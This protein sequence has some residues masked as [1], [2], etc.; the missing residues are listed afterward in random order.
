MA[1]LA[2]LAHSPHIRPM[3][4]LQ[5]L[6][7]GVLLALLAACA[8]PPKPAPIVP[9]PAQ[10]QRPPNLAPH[11]PLPGWEAAALTPGNWV[12][13]PEG[14][15]AAALF[16]MPA[17]PALLA[18]R[19]APAERRILLQ[20][21]TLDPPGTQGVLQVQTSSQSRTLQATVPFTGA[22]YLTAAL[23]ATDT[24]WD[25]IAF[26]RGRWRLGGTG[27]ADLIL[28]RAAELGRVVE[29]CR[30]LAGRSDSDRK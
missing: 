7:G 6:F 1:W 11:H 30:S 23:P 5:S 26:T 13:R 3:L 14:E 25:A 15:A 4:R 28:P 2:N 20:R 8:T 9:P 22:V 29:E 19:C 24:F 17:S 12:Y 18:V 21:A 16:G 27:M 10:T